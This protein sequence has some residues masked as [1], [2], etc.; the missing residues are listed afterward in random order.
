MEKTYGLK[1]KKCNIIRDFYDLEFIIQ[2]MISSKGIKIAQ[3]K[4]FR[5]SGEF[6]GIEVN[7]M[8]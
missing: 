3:I 4:R 5:K 1:L 6:V 7:E 2:Q 8:N